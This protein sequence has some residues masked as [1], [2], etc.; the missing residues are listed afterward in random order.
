[1]QVWIKRGC[2]RRGNRANNKGSA[3]L[4]VMQAAR[5]RLRPKERKRPIGIHKTLAEMSA[6]R[7]SEHWIP[8]GLFGRIVS[9]FKLKESKKR[10]VPLRPSRSETGNTIPTGIKPIPPEW[11]EPPREAGAI[12]SHIKQEQQ[13]I[14]SPPPIRSHS[15]RSFSSTNTSHWA[16]F[17]PLDEI[18][19]H[20]PQTAGST[21][22][23][24]RHIPYGVETGRSATSHAATTNPNFANHE[25]E[26]LCSNVHPAY[27]NVP[28]NDKATQR[29]PTSTLHRFP[30]V[31]QMRLH[32]VKNDQRK[33]ANTCVPST[34]KQ[35]SDEPSLPQAK[36]STISHNTVVG[37]IPCRNQQL[38][39]YQDCSQRRAASTTNSPKQGQEPHEQPPPPQAPQPQAT[40]S[41]GSGSSPPLPPRS[42]TAVSS[43]STTSSKSATKNRSL[44]SRVSA[45]SILF[46]DIEGGTAI[47]TPEFDD[48]EVLSLGRT[49]NVDPISFD[50]AP[51]RR[52]ICFVKNCRQELD[53]HN[54]IEKIN[55]KISAINTSM[56][57]ES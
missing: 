54:Q 9:P 30:H 55:G 20:R 42:R 51:D 35:K 49:F 57:K 28:E 3:S 50:W 41:S 32:P 46:S 45:S 31:D 8:M 36:P 39:R 23:S 22:V 24:R 18:G 34:Q 27:R 7:L 29:R 56:F 6:L 14:S 40:E 16:Y 1:M 47:A 26:A 25:A 48:M 10:C 43:G 12:I 21:E 15:P 53:K 5:K 11:P 19:R 38:H 13:D 2:T 33:S 44:S 17:A 37:S 52:D 4:I